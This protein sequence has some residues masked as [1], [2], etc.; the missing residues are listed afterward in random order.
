VS[1][2]ADRAA[3]L[4]AQAAALDSIAV[5]EEA[6]LDAKSAYRDAL[7][8]PDAKAAHRAASQALTEAREELRAT[9]VAV[10]TGEGS[11]TIVPNS[12]KVG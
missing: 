8:D 7:G 4:R 2:S 5:L 3:E 6:S 9:A 1:T 10:A 12:V 11:T